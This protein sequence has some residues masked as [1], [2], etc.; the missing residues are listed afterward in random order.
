[1]THATPLRRRR[2]SER[3]SALAGLGAFVVICAGLSAAALLPAMARAR[4]VQAAADGERAFQLAEAGV[5]WGIAKIRIDGGVLPAAYEESRTPGGGNAGSCTVRYTPGNANGRDD[6]DDGTTDELDENQYIQIVS[7]GIINKQRRSVRVMMRRAIEIPKITAALQ[8]NVE[9]PIVDLKGNA[10]LISG[11]DHDLT[12]AVVAGGTAVAGISAPAAVAEI[13][14]QIPSARWARVQGSGATS[15]SVQHVDATD[16]D[17]LVEQA[18]AAKTHSITP[19]TLAGLNVGTAAAPVVAVVE[20]SIHLT[21]QSTG[22]GVLVVDGDLQSSGQFL[23]TGLVL[24]RGR[25]TMTGGGSGKRV[26]GGILVGE[27]VEADTNTTTVTVTGTVDMFYSSLAIQIASQ[28]FAMMT[29]LSWE[30]VANP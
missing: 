10:F 3:G 17:L 21:G 23:W 4:E 11:F 26:I 24:V 8:I 28:R 12:G 15:P 22:V 6:D 14:S 30:E 16:L 2:R 20:G 19:G 1:M 29:M 25:A 27:E 7:T 18:K 13:V 9:H 5:D